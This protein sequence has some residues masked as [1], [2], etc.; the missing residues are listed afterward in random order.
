MLPALLPRSAPRTAGMVAV[1]E[2]LSA[3]SALHLA[4]SGA[5]LVGC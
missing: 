2:L 3:V 4:L 1:M 5:V